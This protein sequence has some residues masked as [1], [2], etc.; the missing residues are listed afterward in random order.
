MEIDKVVAFNQQ[1]LEHM[2]LVQ[3]QVFAFCNEL[4]AEAIR[5]DHS[6]FCHKEYETFVA[7]RESLNSSK[8][9]MDLAYRTFLNGESIQHHITEN[10]HHPEYWDK[11]GEKMPPIQAIIMYMD[12]RSRSIQRGTDFDDFWEFNCSKLKNQPD[13]LALV[14]CLKSYYNPA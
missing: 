4:L 10:R 7:S 2:A 11:R 1:Q 6:K 14:C 3:E 8:D 12:W 5:H 9:G 13:A